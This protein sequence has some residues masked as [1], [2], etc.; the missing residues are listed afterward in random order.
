[1][2]LLWRDEQELVDAIGVQADGSRMPKHRVAASGWGIVRDFVVLPVLR[3]RMPE[4]LPADLG[5]LHQRCNVTA[6]RRSLGEAGRRIAWV[7][8]ADGMAVLNADA[9][10]LPGPPDRVACHEQCLAKIRMAEATC[11]VLAEAVRFR[12]TLVAINAPKPASTRAA[13]SQR[14]T[15]KPTLGCLGRTRPPAIHT[16]KA[17]RHLP[18]RFTVRT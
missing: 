2:L 14:A 12:I 15:R 1:M 17:Q 6:A 7:W 3:A 8:R 9:A 13:T 5:P 10:M 16:D 18:I 11:R 4:Y